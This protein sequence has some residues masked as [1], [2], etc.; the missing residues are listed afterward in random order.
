MN[1]NLEY[2]SF[3]IYRNIFMCVNSW[4]LN[5]CLK[6]LCI[7]NFH[8]QYQLVFHSG[9]TSWY[10]HQQLV[11][12]TIANILLPNFWILVSLIDDKWNV[13]VVLICP[14]GFIEWGWVVFLML[15]SHL[16]CLYVKC[17]FIDFAYFSRVV[18]LFPI[19]F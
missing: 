8:I 14:F 10:S 12:C 13:S 15:I 7:C 3:C 4:K 11:E 9:C 17:L 19:E 16:H 6:S 1:N 5:C 18:D 2:L